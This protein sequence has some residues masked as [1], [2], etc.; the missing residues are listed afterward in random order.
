MGLLPVENNH[1]LIFKAS[2]LAPRVPLFFDIIPL[3]PC[4]LYPHEKVIN[5]L[6]NGHILSIALLGEYSEI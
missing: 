2:G 1:L 6:L 5:I 4:C 3:L